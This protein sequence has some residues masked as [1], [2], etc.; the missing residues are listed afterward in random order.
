VLALA[1]AAES[2]GHKGRAEHGRHHTREVDQAG[3][4]LPHSLPSS[5]TPSQSKVKPTTATPV[6]VRRVRAAI[7]SCCEPVAG[8][9][10]A[11]HDQMLAPVTPRPFPSVPD[12]NTRTVLSKLSEHLSR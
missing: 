5:Q 4:R 1:R 3:G 8:V 12:L 2:A 10:R 6:P 11:A 9:H 7:G